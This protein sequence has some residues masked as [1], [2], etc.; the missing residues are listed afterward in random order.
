[1]IRPGPYLV[2]MFACAEAIDQLLPLAAVADEPFDGDDLQAVLLGQLVEILARGAIALGIEDLAEDAGGPQAGHADQVDG[3]LRMSCPPQHPSLL[4]NQGKE[5]AGPEKIA[6][7]IGRIDDGQDRGGPL[8]GGNARAARAVIDR[9]GKIRAQRS[10]VLV[11]HRRQM[12]PLANVGQ[13]RH[14]ELAAA[15]G[16]HEV[17]QRRRHFL[18]RANEVPLVLAILIIHDDDDLAAANGLDGRIN[19]R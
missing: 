17:D 16:D 7:L 13:N 6:G 18:G 9:H 8:L 12:E 15:V 10:R 11:D 3:G 19:A 5:V 14:A 1:M 4:G 2:G